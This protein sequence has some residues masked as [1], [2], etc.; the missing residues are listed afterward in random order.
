MKKHKKIAQFYLCF[1][2]PNFSSCIFNFSISIPE[3]NSW[4]NAKIKRCLA[5]VRATYTF[6]HSL[7]KYSSFLSSS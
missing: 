5:L 3:S 6:F 4:S 2:N 1:S 7:L